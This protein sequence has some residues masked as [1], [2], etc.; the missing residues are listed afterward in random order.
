MLCWSWWETV[1]LTHVSLW[2]FS[3]LNTTQWVQHDWPGIIREPEMC[4]RKR[5]SLRVLTS[6]RQSWQEAMSGFGN[7]WRVRDATCL[8]AELERQCMVYNANTIQRR[9]TSPAD[10][11]KRV[12]KMSYWNAGR[13]SGL[14]WSD[15][16]ES[17]LQCLKRV[18]CL[19]HLRASQRQ[20]ITAEMPGEE[21]LCN[22]YC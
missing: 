3:V 22:N 16:I 13:D 1:V 2:L 19:E 15:S 12:M 17:Q 20:W 6:E 10:E 4:F 9:G 5:R 21:L 18:A 8:D 14:S 11:N 7:S